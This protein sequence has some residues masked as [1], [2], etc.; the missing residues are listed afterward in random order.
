[1]DEFRDPEKDTNDH[2][3]PTLEL[4]FVTSPNLHTSL[5]TLFENVLQPGGQT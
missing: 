1:M 3:L 5:Y 4:A 2:E